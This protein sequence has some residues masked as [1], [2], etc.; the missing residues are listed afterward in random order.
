MATVHVA[1]Y[2][3]DSTAGFEWDMFKAN[4]IERLRPLLDARDDTLVTTVELPDAV[5]RQGDES[6]TNWLDSNP[7]LWEPPY[8]GRAPELA[9]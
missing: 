3:N 5:L 9:A 6:V 8:G 7:N 4:A 2:A 1:A